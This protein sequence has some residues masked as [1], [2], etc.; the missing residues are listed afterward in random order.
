[1]NTE[2]LYHESN[3]GNHSNTSV[4]NFSV[5]EPFEG[6]R[7]SIFQDGSSQRRALV[8]GLGT[9]TESIVDAGHLK[10]IGRT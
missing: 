6:I 3:S 5:L 4:L 9:D 2:F 7:A 8:S 10:S 1:M